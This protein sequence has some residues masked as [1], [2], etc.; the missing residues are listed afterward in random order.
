MLP[1]SSGLKRKL[2]K[3]PPRIRQQA[4]LTLQALR[5]EVTCS[6]EI[7]LD[8]HQTT[9][10]YIPK[11]EFFITNRCDNFKSYKGKVLTNVAI[12]IIGE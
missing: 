3:K 7:S 4:Y 5:L 12:L 6:S 11:T 1:P 2:R 9:W 10:H 8:F